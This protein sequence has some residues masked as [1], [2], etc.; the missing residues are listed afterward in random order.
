MAAGAGWLHW[1]ALHL[2]LLGGISQLVLGPGSSSCARSWRPTRRARP[3]DN[4]RRSAVILLALSETAVM[5]PLRLPSSVLTLTALALRSMR[6]IGLAAM[7][8]P[9][10]CETG[11]AEH[12]LVLIRAAALDALTEV[13][14]V[15]PTP[16]AR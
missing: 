11:C 7:S 13:N 16:A 4:D 10:T 8:R 1:L 12:K 3:S 15:S 2:L 5:G 9:G 14:Q 6:L